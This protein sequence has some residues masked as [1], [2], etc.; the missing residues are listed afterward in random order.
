MTGSK[1]VWLIEKCAPKSL[2]N[3]EEQVLVNSLREPN[4]HLAQV[5]KKL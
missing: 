2:K 1:I 3:M 4:Y 5:L